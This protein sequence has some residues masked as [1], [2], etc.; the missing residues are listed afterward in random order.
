L[1]RRLLGVKTEGEKKGAKVYT[2]VWIK[3]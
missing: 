1:L 2:T 3:R